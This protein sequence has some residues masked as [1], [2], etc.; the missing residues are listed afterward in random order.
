MTARRLR[1]A[2]VEPL[3]ARVLRYRIAR[4]YSLGDLASAAD[5]YAGLIRHLE[6]G[7]AVDKRI[8]AS[9]SEALGVRL[10][11]LVCGE[12][13]CAQPSVRSIFAPGRRA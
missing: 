1:P 6:S 2:P 4:G 11:R 10:C 9:L 7:G 13:S 8:L 5:V 12:H 3:S